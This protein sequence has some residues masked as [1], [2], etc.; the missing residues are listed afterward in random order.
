MKWQEDKKAQRLASKGA[1]GWPQMWGAMV[2]LTFHH[3]QGS[4]DVLKPSTL[5]LPL[6]LLSTV[7]SGTQCESSPD[8]GMQGKLQAASV[9]I[10]KE[11]TFS[12]SASQ[13]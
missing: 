1:E 13:K 2:K 3:E 5:Q 11:E 4:L 9:V 10:L 7:V 6:L 12:T 8:Q